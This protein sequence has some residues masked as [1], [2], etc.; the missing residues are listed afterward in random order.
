MLWAC[1][2][3]ASCWRKPSHAIATKESIFV[4]FHP[5]AGSGAGVFMLTIMEVFSG[6]LSNMSRMETPA[7]LHSV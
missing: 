4:G 7:T 2:E 3:N 6:H 1:F 5:Q